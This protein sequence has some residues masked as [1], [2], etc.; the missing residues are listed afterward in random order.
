[1]HRRQQLQVSESNALFSQ[2]AL[3]I[4]LHGFMKNHMYNFDGRI[5]PQHSGGATGLEITALHRCL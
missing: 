4:C 1:M 2:R 5:H 3:K